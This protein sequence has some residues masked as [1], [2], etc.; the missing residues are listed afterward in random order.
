MQGIRIFTS[1]DEARREGFA[2]FEKTDEGYLMRRDEGGR[3]ALALVRI[4]REIADR[5]A[6]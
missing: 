6:S 5:P 1:L 3:F 2:I 4:D